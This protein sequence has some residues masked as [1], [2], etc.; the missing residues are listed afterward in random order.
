MVRAGYGL[1]YD[2]YNLTFFLTS[3]AFRPP[4]IDGLPIT[5]NMDVGTFLLNIVTVQGGPPAVGP[6]EAARV[7]R[8]FFLGGTFPPNLRVYQGGSLVDPNRKTP[9]SGQASLQI[10]REVSRSLLLTAGY[11]FV[12]SHKQVRAAN[13]N[14]GQPVGTLPN[15]KP[16]FG[17]SK[18][19][20][21]A[22]LFYQT[23]NSGNS[24]YHGL[25]VS[26]AG[27]YGTHLRLNA[28]YTFSKTMDDGT[29]TV[30]VHTPQDL[31]HRSQERALS[32]QDVRHRF[33]SSF[34]LAGPD[35][36]WLRGF[37]LS[38]IVTLQ[39]PR[40]FTIFVGFDANQDTN[41]VTDRVGC[42]RGTPTWA[43]A[44]RRWTLASR[45]TSRSGAAGSCSSWWRRS[46]YST[47]QT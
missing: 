35:K 28:N 1:F 39:S 37:E 26:A 18:L 30:F 7:A 3:A 44:S 31:Y 43:T 32:I 23:D 12:G 11:L 41:P 45:V 19:D 6:D 13:R 47:A 4:R 36:T 15:G 40:P 16:F 46:T 22:G 38:G 17:F 24:A 33:V 9:Y 10:E 42:R 8:A 25:S 14:I 20:P 29:F 2:R 21:N 27:R 34:M 5:N